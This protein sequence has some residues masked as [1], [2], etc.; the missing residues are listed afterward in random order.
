MAE[1]KTSVR[2]YVVNIRVSH[3]YEVRPKPQIVFTL[4]PRQIHGGWGTLVMELQIQKYKAKASVPLDAYGGCV[5]RQGPL[6]SRSCAVISARQ[7][8][9]P[10][11]AVIP[12]KT[13]G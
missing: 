12:V 5:R 10:M 6:K 2:S 1:T 4:T 13:S 3:G 11:Q 7:A 9:G 8:L